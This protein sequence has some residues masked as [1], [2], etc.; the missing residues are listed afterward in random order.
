[1]HHHQQNN[2]EHEGHRVQ[3]IHDAHHDVVHAS[4][5]IAC[6]CTVGHTNEQAYQC[7]HN[8]D[9]QGDTSA[10]ERPHKKIPTN[11]VGA[12][13]VLVS[14]RWCLLNIVPV[15]VI[16]G[17]GTQQRAKNYQYKNDSQDCQRRHRCAV[18]EQTSAGVIPQAAALHGIQVRQV[19]GC[20]VGS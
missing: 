2:E 5:E 13:V 3:N 11:P 20:G 18:T 7:G 16:V 1:E 14:H 15:G 4:A 8:T 19:F 12:K 10:V 9:H 17:V 6:R